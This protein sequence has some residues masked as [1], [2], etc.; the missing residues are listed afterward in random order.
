M[1]DVLLVACLL[2]LAIVPTRAQAASTS[3]LLTAQ[4]DPPIAGVRICWQTRCFETDAAGRWAH[5]VD[6]TT[7]TNYELVVTDG[8]VAVIGVQGAAGMS[9]TWVSDTR[10]RFRFA[11]T[12][13]ASSGPITIYVST[14]PQPATTAT[15]TAPKTVT[16]VPTTGTPEPTPWPTPTVWGGALGAEVRCVVEAGLLEAIQQQACLRPPLD[17]LELVLSPLYVAALAYAPGTPGSNWLLSPGVPLTGEVQIETPMGTATAMALAD[18]YVLRIGAR[19][20]VCQWGA[21]VWG[22]IRPGMTME[23]GG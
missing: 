14:A 17:P 20:W 7:G 4:L 11:S 23:V 19:L 13:P 21:C 1:R 5:S 12:P 6:V 8:S 10:V 15:P 2:A 22:E 16:A 18:V 9:V 3:T